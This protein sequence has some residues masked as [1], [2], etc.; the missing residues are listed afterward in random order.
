MKINKDGTIHGLDGVF[1]TDE[2]RGLYTMCQDIPPPTIG[3]H[4]TISALRKLREIVTERYCRRCTRAG[5]NK[6][7]RS[8][9]F[10]CEVHNS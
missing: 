6:D 2:L 7:D 8:G 3:S 1:T 10:Y 9:Y 5:I 4:E